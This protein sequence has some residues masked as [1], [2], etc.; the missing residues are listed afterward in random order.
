MGQVYRKSRVLWLINSFR[1]NHCGCGETELVS[2][3]WYPHHKK[4][5]NLVYRNSAKS[6]ERQEAQKLMDDSTP[7]CRNCVARLENGVDLPFIL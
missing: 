6:K 4:I 7:V 3:E 1:N 2:L 5:R